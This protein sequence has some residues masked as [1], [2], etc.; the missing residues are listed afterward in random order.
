MQ[1]VAILKHYSVFAEYSDYNDN[2]QDLIIKIYI[3]NKQNIEF[4]V[5][6]YL[7]QYEIYFL[8]YKEYVLCATCHPNMNHEEILVFL[9]N[10]KV[11]F[12]ELLSTEN[13]ELSLKTT[14]LIKRT[15]EL[16]LQ[17][18]S[19]NKISLIEKEIQENVQEKHNLLKEMI[20]KDVKLELQIDKS[21]SLKN[22]V[23]F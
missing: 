10:L 17:K 9:Q 6:P 19:K 18:Q 13:G 3:A 22:S 1:Y 12:T 16:F 20:E 7:K 2:F 4:Y 14:K 15:V 23:N 21:K 11:N 5:I 8:H